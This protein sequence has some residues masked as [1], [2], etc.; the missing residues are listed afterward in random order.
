MKTKLTAYVTALAI[1]VTPFCVFAGEKDSGEAT[2]EIVQDH[3]Q[4]LGTTE[5][6]AQLDSDSSHPSH[7]SEE[8]ELVEEIQSE[9]GD[10]LDVELTDEQ[11]MEIV[12]GAALR[13]L[14][15]IHQFIDLLSIR[16]FTT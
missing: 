4:I 10:E 12:E 6:V 2:Q 15:G 9:P 11:K 5:A 3:A 8:A 16:K 13:M 1:L 14:C 7:D